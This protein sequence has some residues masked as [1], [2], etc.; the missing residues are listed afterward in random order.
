[1]VQPPTT[2]RRPHENV[3]LAAARGVA[4]ASA[5]LFG[6]AVSTLSPKKTKKAATATQ[7]QLLRLC[8]EYVGGGRDLKDF[9]GAIGHN[10]RLTTD[11][12]ITLQI[13]EH[14]TSLARRL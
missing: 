13:V 2:S 1:M 5:N 11:V 8:T 3:S 10:M 12:N 4:E 7:E 9:M 14:Y 6:H